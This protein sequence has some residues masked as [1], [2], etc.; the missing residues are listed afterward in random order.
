MCRERELQIIVTTH[1]PYILEELP[2]EARIQIFFQNGERQA[3]TGVSPEFALSKM[4]ESPHPEC[5]IYVEDTTALILLNE[6]ISQRNPDL[7]S[8]LF[9]TTFGSASVGYQLGTMVAGRRFPR[10]VGVFLDGD[11]EEGQGC[12]IL[13]GKDAPERVVF[14]DLNELS[15]GDLWVRTVRDISMV[16]DACSSSLALSDHHDWIPEAAKRLRMGREVLWHMMCAEWVQRCLPEADYARITRY[17]E[18]RLA[19]FS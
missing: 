18:D 12:C 19:E 3:M 14:E 15:W 16:K 13:P 9:L 8:R 4:D 17:I 10:A 7:A 6:M 5:E 2:R 1:S 11:C